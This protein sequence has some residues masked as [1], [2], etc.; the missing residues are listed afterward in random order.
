MNEL[1]STDE[2]LNL[3]YEKRVD[4]ALL[5][6][7]ALTFGGAFPPLNAGYLSWISFVPYFF[8]LE[9]NIYSGIFRKNF[10]AGYAANLLIVYWIAANSG[11]ALPVAYFTL[12]GSLAILALWFTLYGWAQSRLWR[13]WGEKTI[14]TA[15]L[16]WVGIEFIRSHGSLAFPWTMVANTQTSY[17][18]LIQI[19]SVTGAWGVS[20]MII[21]VNV[22]FYQAVKSIARLKRA[23]V[24]L[25]AAVLT[26]SSVWI[27]GFYV[28]DDADELLDGTEK[29]IKVSIVQPNLDPKEKWDVTKRDEV[30]DL[31]SRLYAEAALTKPD[32]IIWPETATPAYLRANKDN[33][34]DQIL[35]MVDSFNV[36]LL[37]GTLD[38]KFSSDGKTRK[39]NS[40]FLLRPGSR[41]IESYSKIHLVPF[42]E[43]VPFEDRFP[44]LS[45]IDLGQA[46]FSQGTELTVFDLSG[47]KF[48]VE[49]CFESVFPSLARKFIQRGAELIVIITNDAWFGNTSGP[50]QH[51]QTAVMRAVENRRAVARCA[52]TGISELIDPYGRIIDSIRLNER[53]VLTGELKLLNIETYYARHGDYLGWITAGLSV[54]LMLSTLQRVRV[55]K[56]AS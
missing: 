18:N 24:Y 9:R 1:S 51:A 53:G 25:S 4:Y 2:R 37:T 42:A 45:L 39:Y 30:Y 28:M 29:S 52:N 40:A 38:Y 54:L 34:L 10:A 48:S 19:S 26:L 47:K 35:S 44:I 49:I 14:W 17:T 36:P 6:F 3:V 50:Y 43:K 13:I 12:F 23:L 11:A 32:L 56:S 33:R 20:F 27:Y 31:Y 7:F 21:L 8:F 46:N 41:R 15:P 16:L 55:K 22:F 5:G